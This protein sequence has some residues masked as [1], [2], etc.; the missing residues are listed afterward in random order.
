MIYPD[1]L[2]IIEGRTY[3]STPD[4]ER[5]IF[6]EMKANHKPESVVV[7]RDFETGEILD[8]LKLNELL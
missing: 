3:E 1:I 7:C 5:Q 4:N 2:Y 8:E 6:A